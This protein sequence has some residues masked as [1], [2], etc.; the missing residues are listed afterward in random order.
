M[1]FEKKNKSIFY[2]KYNIP[3][4][5]KYR[6]CRI[7]KNDNII[8]YMVDASKEELYDAFVYSCPN[9]H[10]LHVIKNNDQSKLW[11][12]IKDDNKRI[13]KYISLK[14]NSKCKYCSC[15]ISN[16]DVKEY[17]V[18]FLYIDSHIDSILKYSSISHISIS[19]NIN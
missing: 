10:K 3:K 4:T 2:K 17:E 5:I 18:N 6:S 14:K 12:H 19:E 9:C 13:K 1:K 7:D 16:Y 15:N 8:S 11:K